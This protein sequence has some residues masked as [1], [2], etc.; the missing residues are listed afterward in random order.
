VAGSIGTVLE[1]A[2]VLGAPRSV[3]AFGD[4]PRDDDVREVEVDVRPVEADGFTAAH[5]R[6]GDEVEERVQPVLLGRL[7]ERRD[8][9]WFPHGA[10]S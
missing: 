9:L 10:A 8:L 3:V 2:A 4:L 6:E 7:E 5:A 1:P